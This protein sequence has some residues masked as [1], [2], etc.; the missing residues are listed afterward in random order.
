MENYL[1]NNRTPSPLPKNNPHMGKEDYDTCAKLY[2]YLGLMTGQ[3]LCLDEQTQDMINIL[4]ISIPVQICKFKYN[5]PQLTWSSKTEE[6]V[7]EI[8]G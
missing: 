1:P 4:N 5:S 6:Q 7:S 3:L 2:T 8:F